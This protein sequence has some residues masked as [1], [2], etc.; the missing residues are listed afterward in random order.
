MV[1]FKTKSLSLYE[2]LN[3]SY[4][5]DGN[6]NYL[7]AQQLYNAN[8]VQQARAIIAK[9]KLLYLSHEVYKLSAEI[10]MDLKN[11]AQAEQDYKTAVFMVPNRMVSRKNLLDFYI[12]RKDTANT[13]YWAKSI[14]NMP[15]KIPSEKTQSIL[16]STKIIINQIS[17]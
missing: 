14:L 10:E 8:K 2:E 6:V 15:V 4:I 17:K 3:K 16:N 1:G 7:Y 5:N 12:E 13:I 9:S 11:F